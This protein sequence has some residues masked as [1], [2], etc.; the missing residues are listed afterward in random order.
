MPANNV[1][2]SFK[3]TNNYYTTFIKLASGF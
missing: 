1:S 3:Y 2:I